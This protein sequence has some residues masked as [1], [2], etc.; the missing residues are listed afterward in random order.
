MKL[1]LAHEEYWVVVIDGS[2]DDGVF[3]EVPDG[4]AQKLISAQKKWAKSTDEVYKL[5]KAAGGP[6]AREWR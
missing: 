2:H 6:N 5:W 1:R 3:V 4:Q